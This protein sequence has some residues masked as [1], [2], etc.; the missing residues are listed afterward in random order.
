MWQKNPKAA[1]YKNKS[2]VHYNRM[3]E[4][5]PPRVLGTHV[6]RPSTGVRGAAALT[7]SRPTSPDASGML[8]PSAEEGDDSDGSGVHHPPITPEGAHQSPSISSSAHSSKRK[9]SALDSISHH[10]S[11]QNT[12]MSSKKPRSSSAIA[13]Q[14]TNATLSSLN[15][16]IQNLAN[17]RQ[18]K[19]DSRHAGSPERR[20]RAAVLLQEQEYYLSSDA[21]IALLDLIQDNTKF[22]DTYLTLKRLDWRVTWVLKRLDVELNFQMESVLEPGAEEALSEDIRV[23]IAAYMTRHAQPE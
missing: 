12:S 14:T 15:D 17:S 10:S 18:S 7:S 2:F 3:T 1:T 8:P 16:S 9:F 4:L 11:S 19:A 20:Q 23:A 22:A 6:F 5:M 13:L 21:M